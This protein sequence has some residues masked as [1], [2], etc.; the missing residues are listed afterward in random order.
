M[1][2]SPEGWRLT[3]AAVCFPT[4][5]ELRPKLGHS[6][7]KIHGRVPGYG[8]KLDG[9]SNRFFDGIK[10]GDVFARGNWSLLDDPALYQP[11]GKM[12]S[13]QNSSIAP[14]TAGEEIWLRVEH[15]TLQ[16]L[17]RSDAILFGIR[18]HRTRLREVS[19]D[20]E[21]AE[22]SR[23][24]IEAIETMNPAMQ[25]YKSLEWVR[26]PAIAYLRAAIATCG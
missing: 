17:P 12:R 24:L 13:G 19:E 6:M 22:A 21:D 10:P 5:W 14:S 25:R 23:T 7:T 20:A 9:T 8:E 4:R 15:Q 3:A 11:T 18:I 26:D 1:E 16:R 2:A